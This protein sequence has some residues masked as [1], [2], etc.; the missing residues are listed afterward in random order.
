MYATFST[1]SMATTSK[2]SRIHRDSLPSAP[3]HW[4]GML[5]HPHADGF[6]KAAQFEYETMKM[7]TFTIVPKTSDQRPLPLMWVSTYKFDPDGFLQKYKARLV[8]RGDLEEVSAED[9]YA[10]TLAI[11]IFRCL[12]ALIPA[13][14][15]KTRQFD[16]INA[17]LNAKADRTIHVY[18]PDGFSIDGKCL[19][20]GAPC[21]DFESHLYCG[22]E[23]CPWH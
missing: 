17:F 5:K 20:L 16:A 14:D 10:A 7:G 1:A 3:K 11:K 13:F 8:V 6:P 15:M 22:S 9:V 18:M 4:R 21:M 2:P 19:L 23:N 12:V